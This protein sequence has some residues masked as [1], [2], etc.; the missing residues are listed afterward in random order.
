MVRLHIFDRLLKKCVVCKEKPEGKAYGPSAS[1]AA[2]GP[3]W[4]D[5]A[6]RKKAMK[7]FNGNQNKQVTGEG[8]QGSPTA[9]E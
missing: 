9:T 2:C 6:K 1:K 4:D 5:T 8:I 7:V 3:C